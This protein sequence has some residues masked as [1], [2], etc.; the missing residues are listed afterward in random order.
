VGNAAVR[1]VIWVVETDAPDSEVPEQAVVSTGDPR[2][3]K[4]VAEL[5]EAQR[6]S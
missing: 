1:R 6:I 2:L 5:D 3:A 4:R